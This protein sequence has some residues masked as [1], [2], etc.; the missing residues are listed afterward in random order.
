MAAIQDS[1]IPQENAFAN[2]VCFLGVRLILFPAKYH[3]INRE[4]GELVC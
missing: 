3:L 1:L 2:G 4:L